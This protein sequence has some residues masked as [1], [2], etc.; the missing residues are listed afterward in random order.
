MGSK[1][2]GVTQLMEKINYLTTNSKITRITDITS[3]TDL[4]KKIGIPV[5][6]MTAAI[7]RG[8]MSILHQKLI[9]DK[10][11]FK[12]D[13]KEWY[14]GS[15]EEFIAKYELDGL[16]KL[17]AHSQGTKSSPNDTADDM[18]GNFIKKYVDV[19]LRNKNE[20]PI[21]RVRR[22]IKTHSGDEASEKRKVREVLIDIGIELQLIPPLP[23]G[24]SPD[25]EYTI[26]YERKKKER[27]CEDT[28]EWICCE[29]PD[30]VNIFTSGA[31]KRA[32]ICSA[33][34]KV[35]LLG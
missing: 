34:T 2:L 19:Y 35:G 4:A 5:P 1:P 7:S 9:A 24:Y 10:F 8:T 3:Q 31:I 14:G 23:P 28:G 33:F 27:Q 22:H 18:L 32:D 11:F 26:L 12:T 20:K 25:D 29:V 6:T 21:G 30:G 17:I 13:W 16:P 15:K